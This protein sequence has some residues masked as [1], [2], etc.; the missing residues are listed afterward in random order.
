MNT[1]ILHSIPQ[2]FSISMLAT[3]TTAIITLMSASQDEYLSLP[4]PPSDLFD[5]VET[6]P[7]GLPA[8]LIR[9]YLRQIADA[10]C[11]L[12][13]QGIGELDY[14][15]YV[16]NIYANDRHE[17]VHRDI[18]DENVV[19]GPNEKCVLID[20][21][22]SGLGRKA[23]WDTFSGTQ[24]SSLSWSYLL[25]KTGFITGLTMRDGRF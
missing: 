25:L 23:G 2:H 14:F 15:S 11:F 8:H 10:V 5:L 24:V 4:P 1:C 17:I 22:S 20:F 18:K 21:G 12:H 3:N 6:Y 16:M 7:Q 19:L 13:S 9:F